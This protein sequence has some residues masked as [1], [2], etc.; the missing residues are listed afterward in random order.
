MSGFY[1]QAVEKITDQQPEERTAVWMV[2]EQLKDILKNEPELSELVLEDLSVEGL[3]IAEC[4]KKIKEY[5]DKHKS[6]GFS[7]VIPSEAE[8]IIR[9]FYG[10]TEHDVHL[11][12]PPTTEAPGV[13]NLV[14][15]F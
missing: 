11:T 6:K 10:L 14:D 3:S 4:E 8:N 2:G 13:I 1:E 9:E 5:A 7:C 15:F 12:A